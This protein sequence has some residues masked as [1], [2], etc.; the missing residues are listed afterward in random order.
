MK[1]ARFLDVRVWELDI[2]DGMILEKIFLLFIK[3]ILKNKKKQAI[4]HTFIS[5]I[6]D[7]GNNICA[8]GD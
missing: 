3:K 6:N 1:F 8:L 4:L 5:K 7:V 2:D